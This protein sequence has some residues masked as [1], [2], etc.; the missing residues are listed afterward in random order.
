MSTEEFNPVRALGKV[1]VPH[2]AILD[3]SISNGA[4]MTLTFYLYNEQHGLEPPAVNYLA[5]VRNRSR[6]TI[7]RYRKELETAG[8]ISTLPQAGWLYVVQCSDYYKIGKTNSVKNRFAQLQ[9]SMPFALRLIHQSYHH[10]IVQTERNIH[11]TFSDKRIRGEWFT[12]SAE[13]LEWF[14]GFDG[15]IPS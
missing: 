13:D 10:D 12:L 8:Y 3:H 4:F 15:G 2:S 7:N 14:E 5:E 1:N 9:S 11:A 6:Q